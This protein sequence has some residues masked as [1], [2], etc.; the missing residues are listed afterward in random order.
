MKYKL[1]PVGIAILAAVIL[2]DFR[3]IALAFGICI[4]VLLLMDFLEEQKRQKQ[5]QELIDYIT[6]IQDLDEI[7]EMQRISEGR[8]GILQSELYK[9]VTIFREEYASE[10]K[11]KRYMSDMMS[12]ISH[13][14]KTPLT[15]ISL[16]TELL[17][18]PDVSEEQR[19]EYASKINAEI[20]R[21]TWLIRNLLTLSQLEAGVL[22]LNRETFLLSDLTGEIA[23]SLEVMAEVAEVNLSTEVSSEIKITADRHWIGEAFTNILKNCIEHTPAGGAVSLKATQ[24]NLYTEVVIED[25]GNGIEEKHLPHIFERFYKAG[26]RS[27]NSVGIGLS[28]ARQIFRNHDGSIEVESEKGKGTKFII[29]LYRH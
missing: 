2:R 4:V 21:M 16:M 6:R 15:A 29:R 8:L 7:P 19:L 14:F 3:W 17:M 5:L 24:N 26:N 13:Q 20:N 12:D 28:M 18:K 22:E 1:I 10:S 27:A 25:N 23:D 11:Q 9:V